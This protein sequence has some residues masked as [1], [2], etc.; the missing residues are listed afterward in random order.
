M[1]GQKQ[2]LWKSS[3]TKFYFKEMC[4][5]TSTRNFSFMEGTHSFLPSVMPRPGRE[6]NPHKRLRKK[7]YYSDEAKFQLVSRINFLLKIFLFIGLGGVG[8]FWVFCFLFLRKT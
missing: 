3:N 1:V 7:N 6:F 4:L 8:G 2:F 5:G